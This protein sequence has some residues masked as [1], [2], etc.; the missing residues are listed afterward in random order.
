MLYSGSS[1]LLKLEIYWRM[2]D[3][4]VPVA[5]YSRN[6]MKGGGGNG[7]VANPG[8]HIVCY[9]RFLCFFPFDFTL[10]LHYLAASASVFGI[11]FHCTELNLIHR[12]YAFAT[13][14]ANFPPFAER[15]AVP[16][17]LLKPFRV[18]PTLIIEIEMTLVTGFY[19]TSGRV[20]PVWTDQTS[21][22]LTCFHVKGARQGTYYCS[23]SASEIIASLISHHFYS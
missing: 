18:C 13:Q 17:P 19:F 3:G 12:I 23:T 4:V 6:V 20:S 14:V 11:C 16:H 1:A 21:T 5:I 2:R 15:R 22:N 7:R 10:V 8:L 9:L